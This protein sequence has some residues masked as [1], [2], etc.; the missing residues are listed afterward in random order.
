[1]ELK[2]LL[3]P[4]NVSEVGWII[5]N[6][7]KKNGEMKG[8]VIPY[9]KVNAIQERLDKVVGANNW[10]VDYRE[11]QPLIELDM[12]GNQMV[13]NTQL[14]GISIWDDAKKEWLTKWDG[15]ANTNFE[16]IKGGLSSSFKRSATMWGIGRYIKKLA[17]ICLDLEVNSKGK[18]TIKKEDYP[19][20]E[21][22]YVN[23][24]TK[25]NSSENTDEKVIKKDAFAS[26]YKSSN[27][28]TELLSE[29]KELC[30]IR[31]QNTKRL[32]N[33]YGVNNFNELNVDMIRDAM[34]RIDEEVAN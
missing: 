30:L 16:P 11:W 20:L 32:L 8:F 9:V 27:N 31:K 12:K 4:F 33:Y 15:A 10:K 29:L 1:M 5:T 19:F 13:T 21:Q 28:K 26:K 6:T 2:N 25:L 14:C 18:G 7:F 34:I 23:S 22:N 24:I 3:E 17:P